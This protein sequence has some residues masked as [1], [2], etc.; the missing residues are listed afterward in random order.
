[1]VLAI[2]CRE[3]V[4]GRVTGIGRFLGGILEEIAQSR[5]H[6][7]TVAMAGRTTR[8]PV[9]AP[10]LSVRRLPWRPGLYFDQVL[11]P[12]AL[13]EI[14]ATLFFSPY[15][16]A[17]RR[18]PCPTVVTIHDLIPVTFPAYTRG[19]R[20]GFAIAFRLWATL[21]SQRATAVITDSEYSKREIAGRLGIPAARIHV[22][23]IGVGRE[24]HPS[25]QPEDIRDTMSRYGIG[26]PYLLAVG[27]FLPHKN[28][29]R[30]AE[31]HT[32]LPTAE[33]E[34]VA[35]VLAGSP[36]G[37]GPARAL[38]PRTL[39][40]DGIIMPGFIVPEDL[41]RLYAGATALVCPSLAEGFGLPV[42]EAMACGTPVVCARAG[43]LPEVAG[44][45]ALYFDPTS[46]GDMAAALRRIAADETLRCTLRAQG[47]SRARDFD[48][49][50]TTARL[51]DLLETLATESGAS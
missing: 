39:A 47:L 15:Y 5:P 9:A 31:A 17:P 46:V 49:R 38:D 34:R 19:W 4:P 40:H 44:D 8:I 28:L 3:L 7:T 10:H 32:V 35:L 12:R 26:G 23:P 48:P 14:S 43:A 13:R 6:L 36:T 29:A 21:L 22:I 18:A 27:N 45:A 2:D 30:L 50:K 24:F 11:L 42:L 37:H 41:P 25:H 20:R 33:R 16:K 51:V 1:M